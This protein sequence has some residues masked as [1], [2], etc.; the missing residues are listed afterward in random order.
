MDDG[1][2]EMKPTASSDHRVIP[3]AKNASCSYKKGLY[4]P[5]MRMNT[6]RELTVTSYRLM[7]LL[8]SMGI[9]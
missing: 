7:N 4:R 1:E 8:P 9:N 3:L 5:R 2:K 6:R